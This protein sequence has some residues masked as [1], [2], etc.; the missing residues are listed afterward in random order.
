MSGKC[1]G[2]EGSESRGKGGAHS[3]A[4]RARPRP[5]SSRSWAL[6]PRSLP[7]TPWR[8]VWV[9][10][11]NRELPPQSRLGSPSEPGAGVRA[12]Q[13]VVENRP[14]DA[15]VGLGHRPPGDFKKAEGF[16]RKIQD[17]GLFCRNLVRAASLAHQVFRAVS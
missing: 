12:G 11:R 9:G 4:L 3:G 16:Y 1:Q 13:S 8:P 2:H 7:L 14:L 5:P 10:G 15:W 17:L 6:G